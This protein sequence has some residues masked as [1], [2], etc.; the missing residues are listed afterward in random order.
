MF[1]HIRWPVQ[2]YVFLGFL[3]GALLARNPINGKVVL[4][5]TSWFLICAGL[6]VFNSY[7]DKDED[8]VGG[9]AK[10]PKVT[11]SLLYGSL[12]MQIAGIILAIA[13]G[14]PFIYLAIVVVILYVF[15]SHRSFRLKSNGFAAVTVN[16]LLGALTVLAAASLGGHS[17][18]PLVLGAL[19]A[20]FFKTSAY[21]MMQVHQI[22]EDRLRGDISVAV[23]FGRNTTLKISL[24][25]LLLAGAVGSTALYIAL[26]NLVIVALVI[27][28][29]LVM[30][31][32]FVGWIGTKEDPT[33]DYAMV[34]QMIY[35]SG[36]LGSVICLA[37]YVYF[38]TADFA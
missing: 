28:Y 27:G 36:Y 18:A 12:A 31:Y 37:A 19:T 34:R 33:K 1:I 8:P 16:A 17:G 38:S 13:I 10:P 26:D 22:R 30:G 32:R 23:M 7:Y 35:L 20:A 21:L 9:M 24:L 5:L 4:A 3:F 25:F 11:I 14:A 29:F 6:T 2:S 15:Y